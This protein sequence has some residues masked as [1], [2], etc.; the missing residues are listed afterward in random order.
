[1]LEPGFHT[2]ITELFIDYILRPNNF[3][4]PCILTTITSFR[5]HCIRYLL[6]ETRAIPNLPQTYGTPMDTFWF[7]VAIDH[8]SSM[9]ATLVSRVITLTIPYDYC[10]MRVHLWL[11]FC[12]CIIILYVAVHFYR[13]ITW[14]IL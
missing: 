8:R 12:L 9:F 14:N 3:P 1:M 2:R 7:H 4:F 6:L 11:V 13:W 10:D 5:T